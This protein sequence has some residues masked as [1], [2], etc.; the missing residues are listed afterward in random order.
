MF[1]NNIL[2]IRNNSILIDYG[3]LQHFYIDENFKPIPYIFHMAGKIRRIRIQLSKS[4]LEMIKKRIQQK[5][6]QVKSFKMLLDL[7]NP[8]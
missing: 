8:E 5:R 6:V 4:Y 7:T 2:D 1:D 3:V